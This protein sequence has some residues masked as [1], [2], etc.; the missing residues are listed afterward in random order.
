MRQWLDNKFYGATYS[1]N[2]EK[3]KTNL[4]I[5][6][7]W[8][9]YGHAKHFGEIIWAQYAGNTPIRQHYYDGNSQKNDFNVY[10]KWNYHLKEAL[11]AFV[12][13]QYRSVDYRS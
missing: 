6:G 10:A 7:A 3:G 1:F 11:N 2:Y 8:N 13:L 5:G 12:D 9:Q 4:S